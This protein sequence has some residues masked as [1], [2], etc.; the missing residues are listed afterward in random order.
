[1]YDINSV[2]KAQK[3][4]DGAF[5]ELMSLSQEELYRIAFTYMKNEQEAL[6]IVSDTVYKAYMGIKKLNNPQFFQTWIIKILI[7]QCINRLKVS[8]RIT[9]I[10]E[11]DKIDINDEYVPDIDMEIPRNIDLYKAIDKLD[12]KSKSIII[13]RYA[14]DMTIPQISEVLQIPKGTIKANIYRSLKKLK[15]ELGEGC[16]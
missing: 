10:R 9:Y 13:L 14:Q 15:N 4:D 7:N 12:I 11:Y 3:G 8:N 1:M 16:I 5:V 6:D 2:L